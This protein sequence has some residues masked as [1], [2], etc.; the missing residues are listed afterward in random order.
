MSL[1]VSVSEF[2][3]AP[4]AIDVSALDQTNIGNV[5]AQDNA[6]L[7]ILRSASSWAANLCKINTFEATVNT[8]IKDLRI[9]RDGKIL[10]FPDNYPV[11]NVQ[12]VQYRTNPF[13]DFINIDLNSVETFDNRFSIYRFSTNFLSPN[14]I[15]Q[16]SYYGY[17]NPYT[18]QMFSDIPFTLK[19]TYV[20][21]YFNSV[22]A[23]AGAIGDTIITVTNATGLSA[24][25]DFTIYDGP[26][27]EY[28]VVSSIDGN[29]IT[30][31]HPLLFA[32]AVGT[33][34]SAIP[35]DIKRAT[36][37][38]ASILIKERGSMAIT[39]TETVVSS[40]SIGYNRSEDLSIAK[41][42]LRPYV[43]TVV[44]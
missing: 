15:L 18:R 7:A 26:N 40:T 20:N 1:Y 41:Q 43:R 23:V 3:Q 16:P 14:L 19:Y 11:I 9:G 13:M 24:G 38:L 39:M 35:D 44:S 33:S 17:T 34:A 8:E 27:E 25:S 28:C 21:G 32:H 6:L 5:Q 31:T 36:I 2:K 4:T 30:L 29:V 37:I 10:V 42:L 12:S 22:L